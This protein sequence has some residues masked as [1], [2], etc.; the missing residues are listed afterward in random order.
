MDHLCI[1]PFHLVWIW[2]KQF[3]LTCPV[4]TAVSSHGLLEL[5]NPEPSF[6]TTDLGSLWVCR[7]A[8]Q[9]LPTGSLPR[10]RLGA[11]CCGQHHCP[12]WIPC[13]DMV[14]AGQLGIRSTEV[15]QVKP[16]QPCRMT[17][18]TCQLC[19]LPSN[20]RDWAMVEQL[21]CLPWKQLRVTQ[22]T[23][24]PDPCTWTMGGFHLKHH[25]CH[26]SNCSLGPTPHLTLCVWRT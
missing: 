5:L 13:M 17:A 12:C 20:N 25:R 24:N 18:E 15:N 26:N 3:T 21:W 2:Y 11:P 1:S 6:A 14:S 16:I 19:C 7:R 4:S 9:G 10:A 23:H 8:E 22:G